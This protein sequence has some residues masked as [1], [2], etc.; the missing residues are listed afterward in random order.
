MLLRFVEQ[1]LEGLS[2]EEWAQILFH[3]DLLEERGVGLGFPYGS[4]LDGKL[5]ELRFYCG[6]H[7]VRITYFMAGERRI[8]MLTVFRKTDSANKLK[9]SEPSE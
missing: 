4:Q 1:W 8:I 9:Q 5:H 7:R 2:D 3:L 6:G